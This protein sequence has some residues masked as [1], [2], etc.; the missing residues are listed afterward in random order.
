MQ[1]RL[2]PAAL[3]SPL[4]ISGSGQQVGACPSILEYEE[5]KVAVRNLRSMIEKWGHDP[6]LD[7]ENSCR[8]K[9]GMSRFEKRSSG[10]MWLSFAC[11]SVQRSGVAFK[12]K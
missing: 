7:E 4:P 12:R 10:R 2:N 5:D 6:W 3:S 8:V 1:V 9:T 11:P